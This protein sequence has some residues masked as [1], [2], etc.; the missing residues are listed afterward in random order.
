MPMVCATART[1]WLVRP[2]LLIFDMIVGE[3]SSALI[4]GSPRFRN[5]LM[6]VLRSQ[7]AVL[8]CIVARNIRAKNES[9]ND[10]V[11][12]YG[13]RPAPRRCGNLKNV[14]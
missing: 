6:P 1:M 14:F 3:G 4:W 13:D 12:C 10:L 5:S 2:L 7:Q 8:Q 9:D 11:R